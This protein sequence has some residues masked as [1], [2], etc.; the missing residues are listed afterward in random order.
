M[1]KDKRYIGHFDQLPAVEAREQLN[2]LHRY[3]VIYFWL[4]VLAATLLCT[5]LWFKVSISTT[6]TVIWYLAIVLLA[7]GCW[8]IISSFARS[9]RMSQEQLTQTTQQYRFANVL[10]CT[11][12]GISGIILF[13]EVPIGQA[14]HVC[15]LMVITFSFW[16]MLIISR[17]EFYLQLTLLLL[18]ITLMLA[19]QSDPKTGLLCIVIMAFVGMTLLI[20]RLFSQIMDHL[21]SKQQSLTEQVHTDPVTQLINRSHFDKTFKAEWQRSARE[22][23]ELSL[24]LIEIDHFQQIEMEVGTSASEQYLRVVTHCLK[25]IARRGSDTLARYGRAEFVTL[26]PGTSLEAATNL[27]ERLRLE[28]EQ[29]QM[30]KPLANDSPVSVTV[31]VASCTPTINP[32]YHKREYGEDPILYPA[33][34]LSMAD[35]AL[36][37]AKHKGHNRV[38]AQIAGKETPAV[39]AIYRDG[40]YSV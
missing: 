9:Q 40:A 13:C 28:I 1:D 16:P 27:A 8:V 4:H 7:V 37:R 26:L 34:L 3:G 15:L 24:L 38:E 10:L 30:T 2:F 33:A 20:T 23:H 6:L 18:P 29:A 11:V 19:L 22:G 36:Q 14:I 31:G 12:W 17:L 21:F 35:R 5:F 39:T 32:S 25:L